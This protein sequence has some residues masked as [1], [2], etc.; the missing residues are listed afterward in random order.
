MYLNKFLKVFSEYL[1]VIRC[2]FLLI[3]GDQMFKEIAKILCLFDIQEI[4]G[5]KKK[6]IYWITSMNRILNF[7]KDVQ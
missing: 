4:K 7:Y 3:F 5:T 6:N 2:D 1:F